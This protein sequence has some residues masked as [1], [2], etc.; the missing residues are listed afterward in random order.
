MRTSTFA[1]L[2]TAVAVMPSGAQTLERDAREAV[3]A[4]SSALEKIGDA[5]LEAARQSADQAEKAADALRDS[6]FGQ[7]LFRHPTVARAGYETIDPGDLSRTALVGARV[8]TV[9]NEDLG[10]VVRVVEGPMGAV[11]ELVIDVGGFLGLG[12]R[13][14]ALSAEEVAVMRA[15]GGDVRVFVD[16]TREQIET[17]SPATNRSRPRGS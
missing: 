10:E 4:T 7:E 6:K 12:E 11:T 2:L 16:V 3:D 15:Q 13:E 14:L 9:R 8:Y 1:L 5:A 17:V